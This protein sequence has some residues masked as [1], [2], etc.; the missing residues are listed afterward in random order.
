[1]IKGLQEL[2]NGEPPNRGSRF[3][4][5]KYRTRPSLCKVPLEPTGGQDQL[6]TDLDIL[7]PERTWSYAVNT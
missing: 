6:L 1:M 5:E 4:S 3:T 2:A 7:K